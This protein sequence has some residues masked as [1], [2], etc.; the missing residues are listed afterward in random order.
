M[1]VIE[2]YYDPS[3]YVTEK[4]LAEW[5]KSTGESTEHAKAAMMDSVVAL[6]KSKWTRICPESY[7]DTD[8]DKIRQP[9]LS[10]IMSLDISGRTGIY[11]YGAS[12]T[13]KTRSSLCLLAREYMRGR[14][15]KFIS[16]ERFAAEA[17]TFMDRD[18]SGRNLIDKLDGCEVLL[19]DD[20]FKRK[21]TEMQEFA[22]YSILE[23]RSGRPTIIT[24]NLSFECIPNVF[25][26][27]GQGNTAEPV[28]RRI[29]ENCRVLKF[30]EYK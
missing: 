28:M 24:S 10:S 1:I 15:V 29:R 26:S 18:D 27:I 21:L 4:F 5:K 30:S 9:R 13:Q 23:R 11:V 16:A 19:I 7:W 17:Q 8:P 12:G 14:S 3:I 22:I 25:T 6:R 2:K 20:M